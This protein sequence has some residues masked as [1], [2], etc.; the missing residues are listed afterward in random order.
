LR[1][2]LPLNVT[3]G[4][5]TIFTFEFL[6]LVVTSRLSKSHYIKKACFLALLFIG[7]A[8]E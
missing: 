3:C 4:F 1:D 5:E 2:A 8:I 7:G 6:L